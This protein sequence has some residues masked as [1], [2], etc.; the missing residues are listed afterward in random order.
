M[1]ESGG[2]VRAD[3]DTGA[4]QTR[5]RGQVATATAGES[6]CVVVVV[7]VD[8]VGMLGRPW[9]PLIFYNSRSKLFIRY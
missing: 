6:C 4:A 5:D 3:R 7:A 8:D 2:C 1:F 9:C